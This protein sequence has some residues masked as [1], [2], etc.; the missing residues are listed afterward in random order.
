VELRSQLETE[1]A[2]PEK[3]EAKRSSLKKKSCSGRHTFQKI[4]TRR[5]DNSQPARP[6]G[7][8]NQNLTWQSW[9]SFWKFYKAEAT[10]IYKQLLTRI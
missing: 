1:R 8:K 9:N 5:G 6:P 4:N 7:A 10:K 2:D 3:I